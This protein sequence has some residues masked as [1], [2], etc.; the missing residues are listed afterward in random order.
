[1]ITK[2]QL[3]TLLHWSIQYGRP[4]CISYCNWIKTFSLLN[5]EN[6]GDRY[7][8]RDSNNIDEFIGRITRSFVTEIDAV[9]MS[10]IEDEFFKI[11]EALNNDIDECPAIIIDNMCG[12]SYLY[13]GGGW[14]DE[15]LYDNLDKYIEALE[16]RIRWYQGEE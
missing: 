9:I 15:E 16:K 1:M 10:T 8:T 3:N 4:I 11:A 2:E 6:D 12:I 5:V 7:D 13:K 14:D